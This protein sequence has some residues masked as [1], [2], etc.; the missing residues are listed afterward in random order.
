MTANRSPAYVFVLTMRP[1]ESQCPS[2][3]GKDCNLGAGTKVREDR[4]I[5][6]VECF[7]KECAVLE[8]SPG[9]LSG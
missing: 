7:V 9:Y 3:L 2:H 1:S 8:L 5:V 4:W 6:T